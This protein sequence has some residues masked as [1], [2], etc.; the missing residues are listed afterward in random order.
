MSLK[1]AAFSGGIDSTALLLWLREHGPFSAVFC[2]TGWEHPVTY[3]Y[4]EMINR[5]LLDGKLVTIKSSKYKNGMRDL[6]TS[7][8]RVPSIR[9]RFCTEELKVI[10][11]IK[12]IAEQDEDVIVYQGIR[13]DESANR[14]MLPM[15]QW[16]D[17]YDAWIE[18][19]LLNWTKAACFDFLDF[20][21]VEPN[22][23]YKMGAKRVGCF[24]CVL[25]NHGEL[26][27]YHRQLPE[28]WTRI[29][30][31]EKRAGRTFFPPGYIPEAYSD[32]ETRYGFRY[33]STKAV[34][35]YLLA[36]HDVKDEPPA[37]C[38]SIYNLC[39]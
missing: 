13:A 16:S 6:V 8:G 20:H 36:R 35:R 25:I 39:D 3:K 24:P 7:K 33:S 12:W 17:S 15:R 34:K 32:Q 22:P 18:R 26:L 10:P 2:D 37:S 31:L 38:M 28:V 27:R 30:M 9:A 1:V 11:F 19:P 21:G 4:I 29:R 23:L 5:T 14:A